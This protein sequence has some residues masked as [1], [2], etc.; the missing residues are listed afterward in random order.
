MPGARCTRLPDRRVRPGRE[1]PGRAARRGPGQP[2]GQQLR[3]AG[4]VRGRQADRGRGAHPG[5]NWS[6]YP[7]HKHDETRPGRG[8]ARGDLLLRDRRRTGH[9]LGYQR[10]YGTA[11]PARS[12]CWPRSA[13]ATWCSSRTAGT[14][15]PWRRPATTCTTSTSWPARRRARLAVLRRPGARLDPRHLGRPGH[16]SPAAAV[17][18][19]GGLISDGLDAR[20]GSNATVRLT[21][22]QAMRPL[23]GRPVLRARRGAPAAHRRLLRHLRPRQR[24]RPG[25]GPA[26][27]ARPRGGPA[28]LP[29]PATSRPWC[30]PRSASPGRETGCRPWPAPPRSAPARPTWSPAPRW[31]PSTGSR[32]CCCPATSSPPGQPTR[33]CR[34]SRT[35]RSRR[36][37]R[38]RRVQ[39]GVA[40]LRPD[41]PPRAAA[42]RRCSAAMRV[43][44]DPAETGAVTLALPQDVQAE[45]H[46]W[47]EEL[48]AER[49]WHVPAP[50]PRARRPRP[51]RGGA[52]LRAHGR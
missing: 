37:H 32:C 20:R 45:A 36:R 44:T 34:S 7:P 25:P 2:P 11:G 49:V 50:G 12:M 4:G 1:R 43:L 9:G 24:R 6:S 3:H 26:A 27:G 14:G 28:L 15:R 52:P 48:F 40:L 51:R 33:C 19:G 46:D 23:P 41:Q 5:G 21:V 47:P 42:R 29:W 39:A 13:P 16:R 30:T 35:P 22:A 38:Q 31:P 10:V 18:I 8:R 17:L